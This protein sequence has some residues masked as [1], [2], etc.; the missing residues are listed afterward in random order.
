MEMQVTSRLYSI[1]HV[2]NADWLIQILD[3]LAM[4]VIGVWIFLE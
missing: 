2:L 3:A 1:S 4:Q